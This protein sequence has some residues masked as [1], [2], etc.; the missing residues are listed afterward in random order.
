M[1]DG[2]NHTSALPAP[3]S[4]FVASMVLWI[5]LLRKLKGGHQGNRL[6]LDAL[7][8]DASYC[9]DAPNELPAGGCKSTTQDLGDG[10]PPFGMALQLTVERE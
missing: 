5:D 1:I 9:L 4:N 2:I 8:I 7:K 10:D 3:V 6:L